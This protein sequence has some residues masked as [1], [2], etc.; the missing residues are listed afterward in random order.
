MRAGLALVVVVVA[1]VVGDVGA[2]LPRFAEAPEY[3]NGEGARRRWR[4]RGCATR[5]WSTSR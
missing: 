4:G 1:V 5:G 3:R 2:A